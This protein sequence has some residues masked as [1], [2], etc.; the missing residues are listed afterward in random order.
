MS[1]KL[2]AEPQAVPNDFGNRFGTAQDAG[3]IAI[4]ESLS[5][6]LN[7]KATEML[8]S[9]VIWDNDMYLAIGHNGDAFESI[10]DI[11]RGCTLLFSSRKGGG[12]N[13]QGIKIAAASLDPREA[14]V[15]VASVV[16]GKLL[17]ARGGI[18]Q[19]EQ[20]W[21]VHECSAQWG[22]RLEQSFGVK[23]LAEYK[24]WYIFRVTRGL[25]SFNLLSKYSV[26]ALPF[27]CRSFIG[28]PGKD[29]IVRPDGAIKLF[30]NTTDS[31]GEGERYSPDGRNSCKK[32]I[33]FDEFIERY[34]ACE[35]TFHADPF[36]TKIGEGEVK[37]TDATITVRAC[38][39][40]QKSGKHPYRSAIRDGDVFDF[41]EGR[42]ESYK[43]KNCLFAYFSFLKKTHP[44]F[45]RYADNAVYAAS[46][47]Q[48]F[49]ATLG[50]P[51]DETKKKEAFAIVEI[52]IRSI[53]TDNF[54]PIAVAATIGRHADFTS[55]RDTTRRLMREVAGAIPPEELAEARKVLKDIF[56]SSDI[57]DWPDLDDDPE[58]RRNPIRGWELETAKKMSSKSPRRPGE[59][60][61]VILYHS[62]ER[63]SI[64][65]DELV[66]S[67]L[68]CGSLK[69][70]D[71]GSAEK[72]VRFN[73]QYRESL[74]KIKLDIER[75][76][77]K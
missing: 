29:R 38:P 3:I 36:T 41:E 22:R 14:S 31:L 4:R 44:A 6:G 40:R 24:V 18:D 48:F 35:F 68:C 61:P 49:M 57:N 34:Q 33:P 21:K 32:V 37:I 62:D 76:K 74:E 47:E 54:P 71:E 63:R 25:G 8:A 69:I 43:P 23:Y 19:S 5:N 46:D 59:L 30:C 1:N 75:E 27:M 58:A 26:A 66:P 56:P 42:T 28:G 51:Y 65:A 9:P 17:A 72:F 67:S 50:L 52:D 64:C 15:V 13:G 39:A 20:L 12:L 60:V 2:I 11:A 55:N 45:R 73:P 53:E 10:E 70:E 16:D 77:R 7:Y